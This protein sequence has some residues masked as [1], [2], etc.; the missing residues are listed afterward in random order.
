MMLLPPYSIFSNIY[1]G[2]SPNHFSNEYI[3]SQLP[4]MRRQNKQT[5]R[6]RSLNALVI[7]L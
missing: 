4:K 5:Y 1:I 2:K 6:K 7:I 3:S